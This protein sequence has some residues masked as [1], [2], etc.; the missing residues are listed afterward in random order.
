MPSVAESQSWIFLIIDLVVWP[1]LGPELGLLP[2]TIL[3]KRVEV[4][5]TSYIL[6]YKIEKRLWRMIVKEGKVGED[7]TFITSFL[8]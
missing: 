6:P 3:T 8:E 2:S 5:I 7:E 1:K 4:T